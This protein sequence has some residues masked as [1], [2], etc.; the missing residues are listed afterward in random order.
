MAK[1]KIYA[2][3]ALKPESGIDRN[4]FLLSDERLYF[5]LFAASRKIRFDAEI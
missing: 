3:P 4:V 1:S 2:E 5:V